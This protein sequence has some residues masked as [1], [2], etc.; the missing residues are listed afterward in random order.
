MLTPIRHLPSVYIN[1]PVSF[2][3]FL[4]LTLSLHN[5]R[6]GDTSDKTWR[7]FATKFDF[8]G[9]YVFPS[10]SP[11]LRV[12]IDVGRILFMTGTI[13]VIVGFSFA[14]NN[15]CELLNEMTTLPGLND[16]IGTAPSTL[17]LITSGILVLVCGGCYEKYTTRDCLFPP[18]TFSNPTASS[19]PTAYQ[20]LGCAFTDFAYYSYNTRSDLSAQFCFQCWNL[21]SRLVLSSAFLYFPPS[22]LPNKMIRLPMVS[23]LCK[24]A[25]GCSLTL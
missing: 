20:P 21:L 9:L 22:I 1:L 4:V 2:V 11:P 23:L 5:V 15:G 7:A 16:T 8:G 13:L 19:F 25:S 6:L 3:A 24:R 14:T 18:S 12:L 10:D 17:V